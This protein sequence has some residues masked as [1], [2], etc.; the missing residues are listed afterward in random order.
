MGRDISKN[1]QN[2]T[3]DTT[4]VVVLT[5]TLTLT[6]TL[7]LVPTTYIQIYVVWK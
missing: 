1:V 2:T 7:T 6:P 3:L 4:T 5:L